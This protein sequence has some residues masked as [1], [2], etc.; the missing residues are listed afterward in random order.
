MAGLLEWAAVAR[1]DG[2]GPR[3]LKS[4]IETFGS[5]D[6]LLGASASDINQ[7]ARLKP[8]LARH[9]LE[10]RPDPGLAREVEHMQQSGIQVLCWD[11][12]AYPERLK[13]IA[14]PPV[15][16]YIRGAREV[17]NTPCI[18]IV[19]S[20]AASEYGLRVSERL[21]G[22]LVR[23]GITVVSGLARGI[24]GAAHK[25]AV[26]AGGRT[27]AVLGH[28][29]DEIYPPQ[30][31]RLADELLASGGAWVTEFK[32]RT[33]SQPGFFPRRNRIISGLSLGVVV[34][35]ARQK[36]GSLITARHAVEE[37]REVFAVPGPIT[38]PRSIGVHRLIQD[39]AKLVQGVEDILSE[40]AELKDLAAV[41][42]ES[43]AQTALI[44]REARIHALLSDEPQHVDL[45]IEDSSLPSHEVIQGL[46]TLSIK[47]LAEEL[48]GKRYVRKD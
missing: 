30:H 16:L 11:D 41:A 12:A 27:L 42:P 7:A 3:T 24:D 23:R 31:R 48:P 43:K 2:L 9:I 32:P 19:G 20:R 10:A 36:S 4:L 18:A 25:G 44:G 5:L 46:V 38:S 22:D 45:L 17:L 39:G 14:D 28:G 26:K 47:R 6:R 29:P 21:S 13:E 1:I 40:T 33:E 34:V 8:E 15:L 35:E 37:G